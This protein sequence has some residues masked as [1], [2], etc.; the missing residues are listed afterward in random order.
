MWAKRLPVAALGACVVGAILCPLV[1]VATGAL[2]DFSPLFGVVVLPPYVLGGGFLLR[3]FLAKPR[4]VPTQPSWLW[5]LEA[6]SWMVVAGVL[7][8]VSGAKLMIGLERLGAVCTW[9]LAASG[10]CLPLLLIRQ[11]TLETRLSRLPRGVPLV[12]LIALVGLLVWAMMGYLS[13][14][15]TFIGAAHI[16]PSIAFD[17]GPSGSSASAVASGIRTQF[18]PFEGSY[19]PSRGTLG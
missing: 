3:R 6:V 11:S 14:P 18:L 15:P 5:L 4:G 10:A 13:T 9:L 17:S 8:L 12:V 2:A 7:Y 1:F 16:T 19:P